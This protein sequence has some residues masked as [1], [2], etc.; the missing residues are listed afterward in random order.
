MREQFRP[1]AEPLFDRSK[2]LEHS[3]SGERLSARCKAAWS[4]ATTQADNSTVG[5]RIL[6]NSP[7][8]I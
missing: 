1:E 2:N 8:E 4:K 3:L 5:P 6:S 7:A